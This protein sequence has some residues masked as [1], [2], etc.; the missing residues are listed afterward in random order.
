MTDKALELL[1]HDDGG[2]RRVHPAQDFVSGALWYGLRIDDEL[3]FIT[4]KRET[5]TASELPPGIVLRH[6]DLHTSSVT[7]S[8]ARS[9][10][11]GTAVWVSV[12]ATLT[13]LASFF[14]RYVVL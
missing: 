2:E 13:A 5:F 1:G 9:H 8:V 14:T 4:S 7:A 11:D 6:T 12:I 3:V 10:A